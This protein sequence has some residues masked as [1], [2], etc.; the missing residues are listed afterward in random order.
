MSQADCTA[1]RQAAVTQVDANMLWHVLHNAMQHSLEMDNGHF[2]CPL[3]LR[4][5]HALI[6]CLHH[7]RVACVLKTIHH[8]TY[9]IEIIIL[10]L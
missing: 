1:R 3:K 7:L 5:T 9:T 4:G 6:D 2:E 10:A 8:R